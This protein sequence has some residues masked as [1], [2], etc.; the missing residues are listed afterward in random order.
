MVYDFLFTQQ[1]FHQT[2]FSDCLCH[3]K[4]A[5]DVCRVVPINKGAQGPPTCSTVYETEANS[6]TT[7]MQPRAT[8]VQHK[9]SHNSF[10]VCEGVSGQLLRGLGGVS[11]TYQNKT[12][13]ML[14]FHNGKLKAHL[15]GH[16]KSATET[17][18]AA[19]IARSTY[20]ASF[21][22]GFEALNLFCWL[23]NTHMLP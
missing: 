6:H 22:E 20:K 23:L 19:S 17:T 15:N 13:V 18:A 7:Q 10:A 4:E 16:E 8:R 3:H 9:A 5:Q 21:L 14:H 1:H 11:L 12:T 2:S